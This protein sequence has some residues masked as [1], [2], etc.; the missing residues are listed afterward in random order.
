MHVIQQI[1]TNITK[2]T[3]SQLVL[4]HIRAQEQQHPPLCQSSSI[5]PAVRTHLT[6][7]RDAQLSICAT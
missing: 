6:L 2:Q 3:Q 1:Y 4:Q 5:P 7:D